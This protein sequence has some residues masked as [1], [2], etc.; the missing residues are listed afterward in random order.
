M[1]GRDRYAAGYLAIAF[2]LTRIAV[3]GARSAPRDTVGQAWAVA[4]FHLQSPWLA[5]PY[6]AIYLAAMVEG[7]VVFATAA[8]MVSAGALHAWPVIVAGA[9]GAATGDQFY[10]YL[11]RGRLD[12]WLCRIRPIAARRAAIVARV[13]RHENLM[14]LALRFA[15]GLRIAIAAAC[16]YAKVSPLRFSTLN[17][18]AAFVWAIS[19]FAFIT[20]GGPAALER[21]G[22]GRTSSA[23]F[24]G[25]AIVL[26]GWWLSRKTQ[27]AAEAADPTV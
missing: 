21:I 27:H 4:G 14:V 23:I 17:V 13:H 7:E 5:L 18:V 8:V 19:L 9:L 25:A 3:L 11:L 15:P 16:A 26:F 24:A 2:A 12:S 10:F 6:A 20:W 22:L 1:S